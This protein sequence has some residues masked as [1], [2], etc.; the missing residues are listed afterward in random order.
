MD[1]RVKWDASTGIMR[2]GVLGHGFLLSEANKKA[3]GLYELQLDQQMLHG[4][5]NH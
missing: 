3:Q 4:S 2:A 5:A 1:I